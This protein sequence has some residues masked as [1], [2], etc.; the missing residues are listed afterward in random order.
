MQMNILWSKDNYYNYNHA[1]MISSLYV[2]T[3]LWDKC[4]NETHTPK[5]GNLES[6]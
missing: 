6:S 5:S 3:S 1:S 4:E 2:A